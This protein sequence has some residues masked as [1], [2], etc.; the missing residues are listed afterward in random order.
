MHTAFGI[1]Y[2]LSMILAPP[3][4]VYAGSVLMRSGNS[5]FVQFLGGTMAV[6]SIVVGLML[7]YWLVGSFIG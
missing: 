3:A 4:L 1:A 7:Y 2:F 6:V 5:P